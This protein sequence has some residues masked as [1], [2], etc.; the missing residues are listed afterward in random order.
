MPERHVLRGQGCPLVGQRLEE[1]HD[2]LQHTD[3]WT[4]VRLLKGVILQQT[5]FFS[6]ERECC[7]TNK[8]GVLDR[9]KTRAFPRLD[10]EDAM[11][12]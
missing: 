12:A 1:Y 4:S 3:Q 5:R 9:Y 10:G 2:D 6:K 7:G 11:L 8:D